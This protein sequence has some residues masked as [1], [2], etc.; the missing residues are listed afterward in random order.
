MADDSSID[1]FFE[2]ANRMLFILLVGAALVGTIVV[3]ISAFLTA[4]PRR[5]STVLPSGGL[6]DPDDPYNDNYP[7]FN[8]QATDSDAMVP[9]GSE[10]M[11]GIDESM[12]KQKAYNDAV[13]KAAKDAFGAPLLRSIIDRSSLFEDNDDWGPEDAPASVVPPPMSKEITLFSF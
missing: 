12:A 7:K 8:P 11:R 5:V 1:A 3:C 4:F 9:G 6:D 2:H 10:I 13:R